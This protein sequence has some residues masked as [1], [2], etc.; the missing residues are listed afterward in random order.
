MNLNGKTVWDLSLDEIE[1]AYRNLHMNHYVYAALKTYHTSSPPLNR[2]VYLRSNTI[3]PYLRSSVERL[4]ELSP[5]IGKYDPSFVRAGITY[6]TYL[7]YS[8]LDQVQLEDI[9]LVAQLLAACAY[10]PI[11]SERNDNILVWNKKVVRNKN[12][13]SKAIIEK[14]LEPVVDIEEVGK[15]PLPL[16]SGFNTGGNELPHGHIKNLIRFVP[17]ALFSIIVL[18]ENGDDPQMIERVLYNTEQAMRTY[19]HDHGHLDT[20]SKNK[21]RVEQIRYRNTIYLYGG[22]FF[23]K[24]KMYDRAI[25]WYLKDIN[26]P[27]LPDSSFGSFM[28]DMR[29][30]ERLISAYPLITNKEI[31]S[32]LKDL[33]HR[34]LFKI[35][36]GAAECGHFILDYLK[37]HPSTNLRNANL[38][39]KGRRLSYGREGSREVYFISLLYN[40]FILGVDYQ[41]IDYARFFKY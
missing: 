16:F 4:L 37:S 32:N 26:N 17:K 5:Y 35:T 34:C 20:S 39:L 41:D 30:T 29:T 6:C 8:V 24:Q 28:T 12:R 33:I 10:L 14:L 25:D 3:P 2:S 22:M 13:H 36:K 21:R 9:S 19:E 15:M 31:Q 7:M 11:V 23:E 18:M 27:E 40:K 1:Y 38:Y